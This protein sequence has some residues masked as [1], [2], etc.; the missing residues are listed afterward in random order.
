MAPS[1]QPADWSAPKK[2]GFMFTSGPLRR[3][4]YEPGKL[5]G[6]LLAHFIFVIKGTLEFFWPPISRCLRAEDGEIF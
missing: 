1:S 4:H 6:N 2:N 3:F 5:P